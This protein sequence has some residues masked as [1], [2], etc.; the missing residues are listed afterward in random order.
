[1]TLTKYCR[2]FARLTG[3]RKRKVRG[4]PDADLEPYGLVINIGERPTMAD[5]GGITVEVGTSAG[6]S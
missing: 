3:I 6:V 5:G 4:Y 1:M 2:R